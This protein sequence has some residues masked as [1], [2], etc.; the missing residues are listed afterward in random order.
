MSLDFEAIAFWGFATDLLF[1]PPWNRSEDPEPRQGHL[2]EQRLHRRL[3]E[4]GRPPDEATGCVIGMHV[5]FDAPMFYVAVEAS[6]QR[7]D[8]NRPAP[9]RGFAVG[10]G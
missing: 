10:D 5:T 6:I 2:W 7:G 9:A 4:A 8:Y 3:A 1:A